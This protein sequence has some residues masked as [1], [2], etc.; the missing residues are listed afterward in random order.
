MKNK[1]KEQ[2]ILDG[3]QGEGGGQIL[4]SALTLSVITGTPFRIEN[5]RAGRAK[6]GLLRQH[7]TAV[8]AAAE[9][10][11]AQV[12]GAQLGSGTLSFQPGRIRGG[13]YRFNIGSAGSC[14]LVLQTVLPALWFADAPSRV[15]I[16][17]G[18]HN[19]SASPADF[20]IRA[21]TP[22]LAGMGVS[23]RIELLRHGFYPAGGGRLLAEV[24]PSGQLL[25]LHVNERG[26]LRELRAEALCAAVPLDVARRELQLL[27]QHLPQISG[28]YR[29]IPAREGPGNVMLVE[30]ES[31]GLTELFCAFG[32]RGL[33][34]EAVA[35]KVL[36]QVQA[37]LDSGAAVGEY[38]TDQLLLPL[39]LAGGGSFEAQL[40][41][42]HSMT[43]IAVIERF[44]P[45]NFTADA[46]TG[47]GVRVAAHPI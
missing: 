5:I 45:V 3:A 39:A 6:S 42:S 37:Y 21:W 24:Q 29:E 2:I 19:Q 17:G 20:L 27:R 44:L 18:T 15:E 38:L 33:P 43:N 9:I 22:L 11:G 25:P 32:E 10:S 30:V 46:V 16:S 36:T 1:I 40:L 26:V 41:S 7:L 8:N 13:D 28:C 23:Q 4:R 31:D 14:T 12:E 34:A 35:E 47:G